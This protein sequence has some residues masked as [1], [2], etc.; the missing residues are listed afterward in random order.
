MLYAITVTLKRHTALTV[1]TSNINLL[2]F[3]IEQLAKSFL[4][5]GLVTHPG[6]ARLL[7][8]YSWD[9][10]QPSHDS[11][12][13]LAGKGNGWISHILGEAFCM[14]VRSL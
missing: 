4:Y 5:L 9:R 2:A 3:R 12:L 6:C 13:D 14:C 1:Y 7:P 11:E 10:L 8:N